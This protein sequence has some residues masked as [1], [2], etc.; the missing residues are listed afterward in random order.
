MSLRG[1]LYVGM[2]L[3]QRVLS[4]SF[5]NGTIENRTDVL[6]RTLDSLVLR[7]NNIS[8]ILNDRPKQMQNEKRPVFY[9]E[10]S[11][12]T[13]LNINSIVKFDTEL[14]D[15]GNNFNT[16]DG[17]FIAPIS[18]VYLFSWTI[19]TYS[20]KNVQTELRVDNIVKG[21]QL[22]ALGSGAGHFA[23]TRNVFCTVNRGDHVWIQTDYHYSDNKFHVPHTGVRS[24][25]MG[26]FIQEV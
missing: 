8:D 21:I 12:T 13:T 14:I 19:Q 15:E 5:N 4:K 18:G 7:I 22:M 25:F 6:E 1:L 20:S 3:F 24:S 23:T 26:L 2:I 9:V 10:L 16:G 11:V 17:I